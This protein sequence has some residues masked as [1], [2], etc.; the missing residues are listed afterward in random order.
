[1]RLLLVEDNTMIG[2]SV[3]DLLR[4]EHYAVDRVK[5]GE[6]ADTA[7]RTQSYDLMLLDLSLPRRAWLC[8]ARC[9]YA[10]SASRADPAWRRHLRAVVRS[11][12]LSAA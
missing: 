8:C 4:A 11:V 9:A 3:L 5:V 6:I 2:E 1:M 10:R 7:L 12:G